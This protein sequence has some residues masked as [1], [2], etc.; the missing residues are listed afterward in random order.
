MPDNPA[1]V[2]LVDI[3]AHLLPGIDD[4]PDTIEQSLEMA[5][6]AVASG[7]ATIAAT[8][9]LRS[10]FPDVHVGELADRCDSVVREL[11]RQQIAL[12][13]VC[14]AEV[15]A[16]WAVE[17]GDDEL[18]LASFGQRGRDLLV[19]TPWTTFPM[20]PRLL[21]LL[22]EKGYRVTLAHPERWSAWHR[23]PAPLQELVAEGTLLQVNADSLLGR[24]SSPV[25]RLARYLC[26]QGLAHAIGSD[27]HRGARWRPVT[28]LA[29]ALEAAADL[30]G[31][32]RARWMASDAPAAI[33]AGEEL[34]PSP[35][36]A[37]QP[38]RRRR[39]WLG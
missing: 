31:T 21:E 3:H 15:S 32:E 2:G 16:P 28:R 20:L 14:G 29:D 36:L 35:A 1:I 34:P 37:S 24:P 39:F 11:A 7:T 19:E 18:R 27:G 10:D 30:V 8:P 12:Q 17:A 38:K 9:H 23:D 33:L 25:T 6:A 13:V 5:R 26:S 22:R 4:G